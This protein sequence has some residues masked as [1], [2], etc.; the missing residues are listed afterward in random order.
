MS[1][2][3]YITPKLFRDPDSIDKLLP[4]PGVEDTF[5]LLF[6]QTDNHFWVN[7]AD[8]SDGVIRYVDEDNNL[9]FWGIQECKLSSTAKYQEQLAQALVYIYLR[10]SKYPKLK[11]SARLVFLPNEKYADIV[12]LDNLLDSEF[13]WQFC[14][15]YDM[16]KDTKY[17]SKTGKSSVKG[18]ASNFY[19]KCLGA[20]DL[21][22]TLAGKLRRTHID[23]GDKYDFNLITKEI[24]N[25][26]L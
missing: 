18:S 8:N 9:L 11:N 17:V 19:A 16:H 12:Y 13:W 20:R 21:I 3:V 2:S 14:F 24:L 22:I 1:Q 10:V 25:N 5:K 15:W 7:K 6:T 26:C 4:E 23:F